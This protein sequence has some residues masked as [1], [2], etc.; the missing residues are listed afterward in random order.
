VNT[1][2]PR[3]KAKNMT[4]YVAFWKEVRIKTDPKRVPRILAQIVNNCVQDL[5]LRAAMNPLR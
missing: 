2:E 4:T 3:E 5:P 1:P